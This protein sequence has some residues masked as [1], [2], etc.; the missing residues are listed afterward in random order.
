MKSLAEEDIVK[1][2]EKQEQRFDAWTERIED[3]FDDGNPWS[4]DE[5]DEDYGFFRYEC[6]DYDDFYSYDSD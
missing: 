1:L 4:D 3:T 2:T 6:A 5:D